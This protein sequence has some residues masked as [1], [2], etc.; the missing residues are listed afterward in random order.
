MMNKGD[1]GQEEVSCEDCDCDFSD[2]DFMQFDAE[3]RAKALSMAI[4]YHSYNGTV[5]G[6]VLGTARTFYDF[7]TE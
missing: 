4:Q 7:L 5:H 3:L 1:I 6:D 2:E